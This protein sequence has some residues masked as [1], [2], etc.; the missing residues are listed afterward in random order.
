MRLFQRKYV[1]GSESE[2]YL[3]LETR[4][5]I[6]CVVLN[7]LTFL[8]VC[9]SYSRLNISRITLNFRTRLIISWNFRI[10]LMCCFF[11]TKAINLNSHF[12]CLFPLCTCLHSHS[13]N[14]KGSLWTCYL[15]THPLREKQQCRLFSFTS[16]YFFLI[17]ICGSHI[18]YLKK[19]TTFYVS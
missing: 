13:N 19:Q 6:T 12:L 9:V 4:K 2:R 8:R 18:T 16:G 14:N 3:I 1:Q 17:V 7:W 10:R 11:L 15:I 5:Q